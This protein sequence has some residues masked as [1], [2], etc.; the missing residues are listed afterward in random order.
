VGC[1]VLS[2]ELRRE[3]T[4]TPASVPKIAEPEPDIRRGLQQKSAPVDCDDTKCVA[5]TFDDGPIEDT[6]RLLK[7]LDE[8]NAKAT[9]F[10]VGKMVEE[11]P[12]MVKREAAAGHEIGNHSWS[13]ANLTAMSDGAIR[14][15]LSR[16]QKAVEK[17]AGVTPTLFRPPYRFTNRR[18]AA[19][20]KSFHLPQILWQVDSEDWKNRNADVLVRR[21]LAGTRRGGVVLMHDIHPTSISAVPRI[22]SELARKGFRFVTVSELLLGRK[23]KPGR[24]YDQR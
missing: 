23:I 15:E 13:H 11:N 20:A 18:V 9:F 21:V 12:S 10:V 17:A 22:L 5:L 4:V 7:M 19:V 16:T 24:E 6:A 1:G 2:I 14:S 3:A 8:Y